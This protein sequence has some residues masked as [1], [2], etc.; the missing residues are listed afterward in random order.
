MPIASTKWTLAGQTR[1]HEVDT[2]RDCVN[3]RHNDGVLVL[4]LVLIFRTSPIIKIVRREEVIAPAPRF[5]VVWQSKLW[6]EM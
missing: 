5:G 3:L 1:E 4:V 6:A 2:L